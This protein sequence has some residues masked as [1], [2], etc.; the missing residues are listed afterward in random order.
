[1]TRNSEPNRKCAN[2]TG[3]SKFGRI[4]TRLCNWLELVNLGKLER[5]KNPLPADL[6]QP[7]I[8]SR[9]VDRFRRSKSRGHKDTINRAKN[10]PKTLFILSS[11]EILLMASSTNGRLDEWTCNNGGSTGKDTMMRS[12]RMRK[13]PIQILSLEFGRTSNVLQIFAVL[14]TD[15]FSTRK[16]S[17]TILAS[18]LLGPQRSFF[19]RCT[20]TIIIKWPHS[21]QSSH[22]C[23]I[24]RIELALNKFAW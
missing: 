24:L 10:G 8:D 7:L 11:Q 14:S 18:P 1:M 2:E 5:P 23:A 19:G 3:Q 20:I 22:L 15:D 4:S 13:K 16:N 6:R 12:H 17:C 9:R 21:L